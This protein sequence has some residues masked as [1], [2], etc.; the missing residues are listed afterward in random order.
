MLGFVLLAG[1]P[2][3]AGPPLDIDPDVPQPAAKNVWKW[4]QAVFCKAIP[5]LPSL[6]TP[7]VVISLD[8]LTLHLFDRS[9]GFDRV[10]PIG[11]GEIRKGKTLTSTSW[12]APGG[13][14]YANLDK[15]AFYD[16][17]TPRVRWAWNYACRFWWRDK[18]KGQTLP[19]YGGMPFIRLQTGGW[20]E[21]GIHGPAERYKQ[22]DGGRL[23]RG[24]V[25]HGCI[26]MASEG[27]LD[28]YGRTRGKRFPVKVQRD[29]ER[30]EDGTAIDEDERWLLSECQ[31]DSDCNFEDGFCHK[32]PFFD[33][34]F[35][36]KACT[37]R[38]EDM[39]G[40]GTSFCVPDPD[41]PGKGMCTLRAARFNNHCKRFMGFARR[42]NVERF[43]EPKGRSA[44]CL[45]S[46]QGR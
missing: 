10:Y 36:T 9:T 38:C 34:G 39:V 30:R 23:S 2:A 19:V 18:H 40:R 4:G 7:E 1:D 32:N 25:S 42:K 46:D 6:P 31:Q 45:P 33:R 29:I 37:G 17:Q 12:S 28:L 5:E 22:A 24:Y 43:G 15:P 11:V 26:R 14:Y 3:L 8:G 27:I 44:V 21:E 20:A 35:C 16:R 41:A 13:V